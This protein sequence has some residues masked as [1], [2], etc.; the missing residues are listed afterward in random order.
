VAEAVTPAARGEE[1][2]TRP[3]DLP[4]T[5]SQHAPKFALLTGALIGIAIGAIALAIVLFARGS[6]PASTGWSEWRPSNQGLAAAQ[7]IANHV[8]PDYRLD[9]GAQLVT[10]K[11]GALKI[12]DLPAHVAER[13]PD[14]TTAILEGDAVL[15][16]LCGDGSRCAIPGTPSLARSALLHREALELALYVFR[17]LGVDNVVE[18]LPPS[19]PQPVGKAGAKPKLVR[20]KAQSTAM[21]F[22]RQDYASVLSQPLDAT[23]PPPTP[24]VKTVVDV[25]PAQA[26][27]LDAVGRNAV[28]GVQFEQAQDASA[29]VLLEPLTR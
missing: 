7:E 8:A 25:P 23:L 28:F 3:A 20:V 22:R 18:L 29:V 26:Q 4:P 16:T 5:R 27:L 9:N 6:G 24:T 11:G 1:G 2:A 13:F 21:L 19:Y 14:G 10:V 12:A 15:F 17:Y